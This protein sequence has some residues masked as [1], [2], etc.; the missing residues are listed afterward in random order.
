MNPPGFLIFFYA[1]GIFENILFILYNISILLN[2]Y[3]FHPMGSIFL[4]NQIPT[5][6]KPFA[7]HVFFS[8]DSFYFIVIDCS[9]LHVNCPLTP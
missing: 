3:F 4:I 8:L 2:D 6:V 7:Q 5:I 9:N 1:F